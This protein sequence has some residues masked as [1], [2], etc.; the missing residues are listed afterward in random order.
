MRRRV[1]TVLGCVLAAVACAPAR[2]ATVVVADPTASHVTTYGGVIAWA[3]GSGTR[4]FRVAYRR[5]GV[6]REVPGSWSDSS[7]ADPDL[8]PSPGGRGVSLTV[9]RCPGGRWDGRCGI[10]RLDTRSGARR[11]VGGLTRLGCAALSSP[12][13]W[14]RSVAF[15]GERCGAKGA[16][17]LYV[18]DGSGRIRVLRTISSGGFGET[19]LAAGMVAVNERSRNRLRV[20]ILRDGHS[21]T[22]AA[23]DESASF[24]YGPDA[25]VFDGTRLLYLWSDYASGRPD[26]QWLVGT[27]ISARAATECGRRQ[28]TPPAD[29][30]AVTEGRVLL[31]VRGT[32][33]VE[34]A[35]PA[36]CTGGAP[37][38]PLSSDWVPVGTG[39]VAGRVSG[40]ALRLTRV[41]PGA[42][43]RPLASV[44]LRSP[45]DAASDAATWA[46]SAKLLA[47]Q[48]AHRGGGEGAPAVEGL[49][50]AVAPTAAAG[51]LTPLLR[52]GP[53]AQPFPWTPLPA[54]VVTDDTVA[55]VGGGC[56]DDRVLVHAPGGD[57]VVDAGGEVMRL[58]AAPGRLAIGTRRAD[59]TL[60]LSVWALGSL[61][62][63]YALAIPG[64]AELTQFF[65][66]AD[67]KAAF[68]Y[69]GP[70]PATSCRM[71]WASPA[72]PVLHQLALGRCGALLGLE[73]NWLLYSEPREGRTRLLLSPLDVVARRLVGDV[74][75]LNGATFVHGR[76]VWGDAGCLGPIT[77][78]TRAFDDLWS[79]PAAAVACGVRIPATTL[80]MT[81]RGIAAIAVSCPNGCRHAQ[82][83]MI[84]CNHA[85]CGRTVGFSL[86]AGG[87]RTL[88]LRLNRRA[89]HLIA[90]VPRQVLLKAAAPPGNPVSHAVSIHL[91]RQDRR[92][93]LCAAT[94]RRAHAAAAPP[95]PLDG[96]QPWS[97]DGRW[98]AYLHDARQL[99]V[100]RP[101]GTGA[102]T[103]AHGVAPYVLSSQ[104][105]R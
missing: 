77:I 2:A 92:G 88:R 52:C 97:P 47:V 5:G 27:R 36:G 44:S 60:Q 33:I 69:A 31:A 76:I 90:R 42:R 41:V 9:A 89:C 72:S 59:G 66:Q 71:G 75:W 83:S 37:T 74:A 17:R 84:G 81:R 6:T 100:I 3:H 101:D 79:T 18:R 16:D 73:D 34:A 24:R 7:A 102:R 61:T 93:A 78:H 68:S 96:R 65:V 99:R 80:T 15:I 67:G 50:L 58:A 98:I 86:P 21:R 49:E 64:Q 12:S 82:L 39:V 55:A 20:I 11:R 1:F 95:R 13:T 32:G 54:P 103:V 46:A 45:A 25:P 48:V 28:L 104:T 56:R 57:H 30:V 26:E 91:A 43:A 35:W 40:G 19:D 62:R 94:L 14:R 63:S 4:H 38:L 105:A 87:R 85:S 51:G 70:T 8:G 29:S 10:E 22:I 23:G 53:V